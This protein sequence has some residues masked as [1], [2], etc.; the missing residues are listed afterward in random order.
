MSKMI[1]W[2][3]CRQPRSSRKK[4]T[5]WVCFAEDLCGILGISQNI[6]GDLWDVGQSIQVGMS[7]VIWTSFIDIVRKLKRQWKTEKGY[8]LVNPRS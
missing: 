5:A 3:I 1:F 2:Y 6:K 8:L 4:K 7:Q